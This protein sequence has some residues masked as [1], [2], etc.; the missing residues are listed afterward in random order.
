MIRKFALITVYTCCTNDRDILRTDQCTEGS[1]FIAYVDDNVPEN[2]I[3]QNRL[4]SMQSESPRRNARRHKILS[5]E[6]TETSY[7]VWIDANVSL[8]VPAGQLVDE[9]LHSADLAVFK[10]SSRSCTYEEARRCLELGVDSRRLIS[11]Q[12]DKYR[13]N[14]FPENYGLAE[15]TVVIRRNTDAVRKFN[16]RWWAEVCQH[17]L[18]DQLSFMYVARSTKIAAH[19]IAPT[20]YENPYFSILNRPAGRECT[21]PFSSRF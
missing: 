5:Q 8:R 4:A 6:F 19:Y 3:W 10:H 12:M 17:S 15:T 20:K 21:T 16:A 9:Y 18:R 1:I 11:E 2:G 14:A 7:S 13:A